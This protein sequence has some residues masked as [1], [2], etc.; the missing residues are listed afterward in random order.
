MN[1]QDGHTEQM[2]M[3][4]AASGPSDLIR[5]MALVVRNSQMSHAAS[6]LRA[7]VPTFVVGSLAEL[8][9]ALSLHQQRQSELDQERGGEGSAE[10]VALDLTQLSLEDT[11]L[12]AVHLRPTSQLGVVYILTPEQFDLFE[13]GTFDFVVR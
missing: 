8:R 4:L 10:T 3:G 7:A 5:R 9:A 11:G 6:A 13:D 1:N 12:F 2:L